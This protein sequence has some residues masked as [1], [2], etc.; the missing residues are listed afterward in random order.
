[1]TKEQM[2]LIISS[3]AL[4][5]S[6]ILSEKNKNVFESLEKNVFLSVDDISLRSYFNQAGVYLQQGLKEYENEICTK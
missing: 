6:E 3:F 1:M 2:N 4:G 5:E